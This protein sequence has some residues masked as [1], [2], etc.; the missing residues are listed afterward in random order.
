MKPILAAAGVFVCAALF[1]AGAADAR[2]RPSKAAPPTLEGMWFVN[3][4][5]PVEAT[6][7]TPRLVVTEAEAR[8]LAVTLADDIAKDFTAQLDPEIPMLI[9]QV[10]GLALV[11]GQRRTRAVVLPADGRLP[12]TAAA[13]KEAEGPPPTPSYDNPEQGSS[14]ERCLVGS[15]Q[16]PLNAFTYDSALQILVTRTAVVLHIEY[17][18]D[19]RVVP[20]TDR[21]GPEI[22]HGRLGDSIGHW[23]GKTLVIE[24]VGQPD[25]DRVHFYPVLIVPGAATVIE[26]LTPVSD[27]ELLYQFTVVDPAVYTAPWLGEFSWYRTKKPIYEHACHEG[28]YSF[29]NTLAAARYSEKLA[30]GAVK[31]AH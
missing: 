29:P 22:L 4:I 31:S 3:F 24:T 26:R 17:G 28:N 7:K 18:D 8:T 27:K 12:Y 15:G 16:P 23:E 25:A 13:R 21:H 9:R 10:D 5:L 19:V 6:P 14:A 11:R 2:P 30:A 20:I 1:A